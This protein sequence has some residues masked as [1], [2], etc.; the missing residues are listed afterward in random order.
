MAALAARF[1]VMLNGV[2]VAVAFVEGPAGFYSAS[3][4]VIALAPELHR[5]FV[6]QRAGGG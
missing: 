6:T 5:A 1:A 2:P 3:V 4:P